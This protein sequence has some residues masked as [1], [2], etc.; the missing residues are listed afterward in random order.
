MEVRRRRLAPQNTRAL[1]FRVAGPRKWPLILSLSLAKVDGMVRWLTKSKDHGQVVPSKT[2][3]AE[4][5]SGSLRSVS[6][7]SVAVAFRW[8]FHIQRRPPQGPAA[9]GGVFSRLDGDG[10]D[11]RMSWTA[12][13]TLVSGPVTDGQNALREG[14]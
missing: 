8:R 2:R 13:E 7:W 10:S 4:E 1:G 5:D 12:V 9:R 14:Q 6:P 11:E 3:R